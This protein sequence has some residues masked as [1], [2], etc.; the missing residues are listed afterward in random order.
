MIC[1]IIGSDNGLL[2][3]AITRTNVDLLCWPEVSFSKSAQEINPSRVFRNY[4]SDTINTSPRDQCVKHRI[5]MS[6]RS[7]IPRFMCHLGPTGPRWAL[8]LPHELFYLGY[9]AEIKPYA[10]HSR[11]G[12]P[13]LYT[14]VVFQK[15][16]TC[17]TRSPFYCLNVTWSFVII[18]FKW[19]RNH[20][21]SFTNV[22]TKP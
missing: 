1:L 15:Q 12:N 8:C 5:I 3:G 17:R 19:L 13:F 21:Q 9:A 10:L 22:L 14:L 18:T 2:Y 4:T 6:K 11:D 20:H 7:L 16:S